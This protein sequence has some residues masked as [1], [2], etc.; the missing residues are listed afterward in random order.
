MAHDP[1]HAP[2]K[3]RSRWQQ[4]RPRGIGFVHVAVTL[5]LAGLAALVVW[6]ARTPPPAAEKVV[7]SREL[8]P[9]P[10]RARRAPAPESGLADSSLADADLPPEEVARMGRERVGPDRAAK[11]KG[12]ATIIS[13]DRLPAGKAVP[14]SGVLKLGKG[15]GFSAALAKDLVERSAFG[16]LPKVGRKGRKPWR[17]Y[18]RP[19]SPQALAPGRAK[20]AVIVAGLGGAPGRDKQ[21]IAD[22]PGEVTVALLP[23]AKALSQLARLARRRGHEFLLHLPMEPWGYPKINPGPH[24]LLADGDEKANR[25]RLLRLLG[26][27]VG[28]AG[29]MTHAGQKLL[30]KGEALSPVLH[31][32]NRRG[33]MA[34]DAGLVA[35][36]LLQP[37]ALVV[38]LPALRADVQITADMDG[39]TA[40]SA[41]KQAEELAAAQ[42]RAL[43]VVYPSKAV[44]SELEP[45]LATIMTEERF[46]LLPAT[47]LLM[48]NRP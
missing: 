33:L 26:R 14:A 37:L 29:V 45:W 17:V 1:L 41:L 42:G 5:V 4:M 43:V 35:N 40:R 15:G 19:V 7:V 8:P 10:A 44:M 36:S 38:G 27:T 32:L 12:G 23:H 18:A 48:L 24:T 46:E 25:T 30:Q 39:P 11:K 2:L 22:L 16:P 3:P 31:E 47:A 21:I 28:Y 34:V 13:V 6:A 9:A 20:I